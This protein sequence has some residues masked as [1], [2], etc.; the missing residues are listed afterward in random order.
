MGNSLYVPLTSFGNTVTLPASRGPNFTLPCHVV[1]SLCRVR[2]AEQE[3]LWQFR[4]QDATAFRPQ[5][6]PWCSWL[7]LQDASFPLPPKLPATKANDANNRDQKTRDDL[8]D[9]LDLYQ[10]HETHGMPCHP[11]VPELLSEVDAFLNGSSSPGDASPCSIVIA[12]EG[13][14]LLRLPA[15]LE[16]LSTL[17]DKKKMHPALSLRLTTNGLLPSCYH[18][19]ENNTPSIPQQLDEAGLDSISIA[20]Q[21]HDTH[22]YDEWMQPKTTMAAH[23]DVCQFIQAA[24]TQTGLQVETTAVE[25]AT[26]DR[27]A[28]EACSQS[29]GVDAPVRWRSYIP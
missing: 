2:D 13:E 23:H 27:E 15:L 10:N 11:T 9:I 26:V 6:K 22:Q 4:Q 12:G 14:P 20:L 19:P 7:D 17:H 16:L 18:Q 29:L 25:R 21:T 1:A 24:A 5:W 3:S 8:T 28:T